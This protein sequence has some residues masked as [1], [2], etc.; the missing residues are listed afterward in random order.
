MVT[1][2]E[3]FISV[4][5]MLTCFTGEGYHPFQI[6]FAR[7]SITVICSSLY[8]WH[9][10]TEHFPWGLREVRP[11]LVARGLTG[12]FGVFGMYCKSPVP[13]LPYYSHVTRLILGR[14][15]VVFTTCRRNRY[16][17]LGPKSRML[18]L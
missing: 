11:L 6:L 12:F 15:T 18:G 3:P 2:S 14:L 5:S 7:M 1:R 13:H 17:I 16:H 4:R 8:M 9:K 10:T